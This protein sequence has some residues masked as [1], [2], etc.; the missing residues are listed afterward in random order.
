[1][2]ITAQKPNIIIECGTF[3]GGS[4]SFLADQLSNEWGSTK[5][6]VVVTI[7]PTGYRKGQQENICYLKGYSYAPSIV[8]QIETIISRHDNPRVMAI[9]DSEHS[10]ENVLQEMRTYGPLVTDQ[11]FLVVE[12]TH[13]HHPLS[14]SRWPEKCAMEAVVEFMEGKEQPEFIQTRLDLI[15]LMSFNYYGYLF[16][17]CDSNER[18]KLLKEPLLFA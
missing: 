16:K 2:I 13:M 15:F 4:A 1:M 3:L 10:K 7:D 17:E 9:L 14:D 12:D 6:N 5:N 18:E 8:K 11:Q